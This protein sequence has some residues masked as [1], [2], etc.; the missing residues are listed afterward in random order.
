MKCETFE[1][2][3][4]AYPIHTNSFL[5]AETKKSITAYKTCIREP[6]GDTVLTPDGDLN[7]HGDTACVLIWLSA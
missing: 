7:Q 2:P 6:R 4:A 3:E 5:E 1:Q